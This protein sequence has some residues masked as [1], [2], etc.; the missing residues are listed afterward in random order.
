MRQDILLWIHYFTEYFPLHNVA[1]WD[2]SIHAASNLSPKRERC[3]WN[4]IRNGIYGNSCAPRSLEIQIWCKSH[5]NDSLCDILSQSRSITRSWCAWYVQNTSPLLRWYRLGASCSPRLSSI[6]V[7]MT[8]QSPLC[9]LMVTFRCFARRKRR[10]ARLSSGKCMT[11]LLL[12][13]C[14]DWL[15]QNSF[16][17]LN[18]IS[19]VVVHIHFY[20]LV[21]RSRSIQKTEPVKIV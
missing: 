15:V 11:H 2:V 3:V 20:I 12:K 8:L 9:S 1:K 16:S 21:W 7:K 4:A 5:R 10:T 17:I 14:Q 13:K 6:I 19:L 18:C